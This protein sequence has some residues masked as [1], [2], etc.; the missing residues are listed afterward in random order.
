LGGNVTTSGAQTFNDAVYLTNAVTFT[1]PIVDFYR[2]LTGNTN[3]ALTIN[4]SNAMN[5]RA[6]ITT[7][8]NQTYNNDITV[9]GNI[10]MTSTGGSISFMNK[11]LSQANQSYSLTVTAANLITLTDSVGIAV[12]TTGDTL[13]LTHAFSN[14]TVTA[15]N[16][17]ILGD[18]LTRNNQL[19]TGAV[20]I[21]DNGTKGALYEYYLTLLSLV[22]RLKIRLTLVDPIFART[23]ISIDP[24]VTFAGTVDDVVKNTHSLFSAAITHLA[25]G[26]V[27]FVN[28]EIIFTKE[29]GKTNPLYSINL[30]TRQNTNT[31]A[32][33]GII[34]LNGEV[35]TFSDQDYRA[36]TLSANP[37]SPLNTMTFSVDDANAK[38]SFDLYKDVLTNEYSL[39]NTDGSEDLLF[40][41]TETFNGER[42]IPTFPTGKWSSVTEGL[43]KSGQ[44]ALKRSRSG[45]AEMSNVIQEAL[46]TA[47]V[48]P[49][50]PLIP[51]VNRISQDLTNG[52]SIMA[53]IMNNNNFEIPKMAAS[54][55]VLVSMGGA[56]SDKNNEV[57]RTVD[58]SDKNSQDECSVD[59]AECEKK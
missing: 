34:K 23:F 40:N 2:A 31:D 3:S 43:S 36:N 21:G 30:I 25:P 33:V 46:T 17:R 29:I 27:S 24:S 37:I 51:Q 28:P 45:G 50:T 4:A 47:L 55:N 20:S 41:G 58:L 11:V 8:G 13:P 56:P 1:A 54:G 48:G 19:F 12:T 57:S 7:A 38:I 15:S 6:D 16:I 44:E 10:S 26:D 22:E 39:T 14:L 9:A 52:G 18:V 49:T 32:Y 53:H 59:P 42:T 5:L 35:N